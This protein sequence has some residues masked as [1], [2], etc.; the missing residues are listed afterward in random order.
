MRVAKRLLSVSAFLLCAAPAWA[1]P[2]ITGITP[3]YG[4]AGPNSP[5]TFT[6]TGTGFDTKP[7]WTRFT[8]AA[9]RE[10]FTTVATTRRPAPG[11]R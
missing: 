6:I 1:Q 4:G 11:C 10:L 9:G 5:A 2:T 7:K 8:D 3:G